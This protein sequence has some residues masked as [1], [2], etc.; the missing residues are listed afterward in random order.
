MSISQFSVLQLISFLE[1]QPLSAFPDIKSFRKINGAIK[2]L[3]DG[4]GNY[5][6]DYVDFE[7]AH[8]KLID[9]YLK[10]SQEIRNT[11]KDEKKLPKKLADLQAEA[12]AD[13]KLVQ[14][15][16]DLQVFKKDNDLIQT[17]VVIK[18]SEYLD[19]VKTFFEDKALTFDGWQSKNVVKELSDYLA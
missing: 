16:Q 19:A 15:F 12:D 17:E 11:E 8:A 3:Q 6:K 4:L 18:S 1:R 5:Y 7:L 2:E 14:S 10:R 9:P 13:K